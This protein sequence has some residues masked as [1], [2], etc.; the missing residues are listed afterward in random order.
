MKAILLNP[1]MNEHP[2]SRDMA[3]GLGFDAALSML[4]PPLDLALL[5]ARLSSVDWDVRIIDA[6][7]ENSGHE[8]ALRQIQGIQPDA[9]LGLVSL[10]TLEPDCKMLRGIRA[11]GIPYVIAR[12]GINHPPI[13]KE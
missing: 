8:G 6:Q 1:A 9:V 5:A 13:L 10:A 2:L 7:A 4:L 11:L 3:G 12:T